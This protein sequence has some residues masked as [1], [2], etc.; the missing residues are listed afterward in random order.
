MLFLLHC[1]SRCTQ[2]G[3][4]SYANVADALML[5]SGN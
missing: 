5:E 3:S 2:A 1:S 4:T